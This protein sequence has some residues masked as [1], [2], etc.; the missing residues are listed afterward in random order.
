M[1]QEPDVRK[2]V[3]LLD[4]AVKRDPHFSTLT[5]NWPMRTNGF[6]Q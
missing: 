5:A 4:E 3:E 2:A 6:M 1:T